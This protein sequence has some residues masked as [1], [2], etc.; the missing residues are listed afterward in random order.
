MLKSG[1][2]KNDVGP[3]TTFKVLGTFID[4]LTDLST[5]LNIELARGIVR[6]NARCASHWH[7]PARYVR[8]LILLISA[9]QRLD[10]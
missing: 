5:Y 10:I 6:I 2:N 4:S 7:R 1:P 3:C 8:V 9:L